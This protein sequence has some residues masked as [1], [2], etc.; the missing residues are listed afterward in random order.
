MEETR[1]EGDENR[2]EDHSCVKLVLTLEAR[3]SFL[4]ACIIP[5]LPIL[6]R[7]SCPVGELSW[8]AT[9][10]LG[11]MLMYSEGEMFR[12]LVC[13]TYS[14]PFW[15]LRLPCLLGG[16]A[17]MFMGRTRKFGGGDWWFEGVA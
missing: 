15:Q 4:M 10:E 2:K 6:S 14:A 8:D 13:R 5:R 9:S 11:I 1:S 3:L 16:G 17:S 12:R 7:G